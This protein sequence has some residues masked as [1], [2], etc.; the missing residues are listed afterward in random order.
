MIFSPNLFNLQQDLLPPLL[1]LSLKSVSLFLAQAPLLQLLGLLVLQSLVLSALQFFSLPLHFL[2]L[3]TKSTV[4]VN[5][6]LL[7]RLPL[8]I[9]HFSSTFNKQLK[10]FTARMR[11]LQ[12]LTLGPNHPPI[13]HQG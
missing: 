3:C 9:L 11:Q 8:H 6:L 2:P 13:C 1:L 7:G 4:L 5:F 12:I 10:L